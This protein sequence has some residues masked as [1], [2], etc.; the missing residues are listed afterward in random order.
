MG[1]IEPSWTK[2][3]LIRPNWTKI[4]QIGLYNIFFNFSRI[5]HRIFMVT[6]PVQRATLEDL[7]WG[8]SSEETVLMNLNFLTQTGTQ[9]C[10][11]QAVDHP[12]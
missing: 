2:M 7:T 1:Q 9:C 4:K 5:V 12:I 3:D 8:L 6:G 10:V 11:F